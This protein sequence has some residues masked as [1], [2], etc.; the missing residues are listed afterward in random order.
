MVTS[1]VWM[2]VG[3]VICS[4]FGLFLVGWWFITLL[5][6]GIF[7]CVV[8]LGVGSGAGFRWIRLNCVCG[9]IWRWWFVGVYGVVVILMM[10]L[11]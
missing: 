8:W 2:L 4:R 6:V 11:D 10:M 3:V 7:V 1:L 5:R 9:G